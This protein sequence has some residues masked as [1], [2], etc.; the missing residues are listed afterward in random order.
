MNVEAFN[1]HPF[2]MFSVSQ[3]NDDKLLQTICFFDDL[4]NL[5]IPPNTSQVGRK[6]T[7]SASEVAAICLIK[8][9]YGIGQLKQLH[10]LL[11]DKFS[12]E[13]KLPCYKN[14]VETMNAATPMLLLLIQIMLEMRNKKSGMIKLV[15]STPVPVCKNIRISSHK[16]MKR[17]A[18]RYK[19]TTGYFYGLKL[20]VVTDE[21]GN[22]LKLLFTT[23]NVDD[24][25]AL[26]TF[27]DMLKD[28]LVIADAG[29]ISPKL[30]IKARKRMN[31][32]LTCVRKNMKK[33][34]T[35]LHLLLLNKRINVEHLFSLLKDRFGLI[36]SLPRSELGY[37]AHY[38]RVLF[39]YLYLPAIS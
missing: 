28:S 16:V 1:T 10:R 17:V 6:K 30:A 33:L 24:R 36:T 32:L 31:L 27:L 37:M 29:Y 5:V 8:S 9:N 15:D 25:K 39:A 7:L 2:S 20:H 34:I 12:D 4:I 35:P 3:D 22:L 13:F 38:I 21:E 11:S 19:S 14:F 23:G 26:D 18:T